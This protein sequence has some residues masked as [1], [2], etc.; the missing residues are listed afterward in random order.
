MNNEFAFSEWELLVFVKV[1]SVDA[2]NERLANTLRSQENMRCDFH[3]KFLVKQPIQCKIPCCI[4]QCSRCARWAC[5]GTSV[6]S[7]DIGVCFSHS[8]DLM[9]GDTI[10]DIRDDMEGRL[11]RS[12]K[13]IVNNDNRD[14]AN[15]DVP[16]FESGLLSSPETSDDESPIF[17]PIGQEDS[18]DIEGFPSIAS[19]QRHHPDI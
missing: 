9:K 14:S 2:M 4:Q 5:L 15:A 16:D 11:I 18:Y 6:V 3:Q 1:T 17:A 10:V 13:V 8:K 19:T 12:K 7:C